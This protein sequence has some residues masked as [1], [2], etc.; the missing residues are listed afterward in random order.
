M[1]FTNVPPLYSIWQ[2]IKRRC[3]NPRFKQYAD[4][5]GRGVKVCDRWI[6]DYAAFEAD[7][8]PRPSEDHSLDRIDPNGDYSP[9]NC[10]WATRT[11]QQRNR[12]DSRRITVDGVTYSVA[13][14]AAEYGLKGDVII[15]RASRGLPLSNILSKKRFW[16][17]PPAIGGKISGQ[18]RREKTHCKRGHA[19]SAENTFITPQ[20]WRSCRAC[21]TARQRERHQRKIGSG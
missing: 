21:H 7:M 1:P 9:E 17:P 18:L 19:F 11:E 2:G 12:R 3:Y 14:L 4:Y 13:T 16:S 15:D 8:S 10:R 6:R 20:G 5:G